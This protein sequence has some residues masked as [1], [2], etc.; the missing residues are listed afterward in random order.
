MDRVYTQHP[1]SGNKIRILTLLPDQVFDDRVPSRIRCELRSV[2]LEQKPNYVTLSY[3]WGTEERNRDIL[4]DG[5]I[6]SATL[7]LYNALQRF[8]GEESRSLWVDAICINQKNDEEVENQMKMMCNIFSEAQETWVW[9]GTER[10]ESSHAVDLIEHLSARVGS[11]SGSYHLERSERVRG[12]PKSWHVEDVGMRLV[13]LE[14]LF[15]RDYWYRAW[16]VQEIALSKTL[17]VFCGSKSFPW[18]H[19]VDAAFYI[20]G[21]VNV[22]EII[23]ACWMNNLAMVDL[24]HEEENSEEGWDIHAGIQRI[25]S[26]QSVRLDFQNQDRDNIEVEP[27]DSLLFLLS[28]HR[29][30]KSKHPAD[31]YFAL[32]GLVE[33]EF[34]E[35]SRKKS[36]KEIYIWAACSIA[37][38]QTT[39]KN[40][41]ALDFLDCAGV[42]TIVRK[43]EVA[44]DLPTWTPDW[45]YY[46]RRAT[47]LLHWQFSGKPANDKI[48]FNAPSGIPTSTHKNTF[49]LVPGCDLL[50]AHG[51]EFDRIHGIGYYDSPWVSPLSF[52]ECHVD[53]YPTDEYLADVVWKTCVMNRTSRALEAPTQ[54][55]EVFHIYSY[56]Q[57]W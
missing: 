12:E 37:K 42:N 33:D 44:A 26:I 45:S 3:A 50:L 21:C 36:A 48:H 38:Q 15:I 54:W 25:F 8:C 31:K 35:N 53:K 55:G 46:K 9:L 2:S 56:R 39:L 17:T 52:K 23:H 30:T 22:R 47:P 40:G 43:S 7:N 32:A 1:L 34:P 14:A 11:N 4:V 49:S 24:L 41:L 20:D 28:N 16:V 51:L 57:Q 6:F 19:L 10:D 27:C 5:Q 18:D 13:A 29:S